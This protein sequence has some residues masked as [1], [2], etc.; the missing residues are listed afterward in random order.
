MALS[1]FGS[2]TTDVK[3]SDDLMT[4]QADEFCRNLPA[5]LAASQAKA[6]NAA[7]DGNISDLLAV[8]ASRNA[9]FT[10]GEGVRMT[11]VTETLR[12]YEPADMSVEPLPLLVYLHGGG[13][14]MGS[15]NS[16][17]R[18]CDAVAATGRAK[19]LA[20]DYRLAP[21]HRY[22]AGLSDCVAAVRY[23]VEHA[24]ELG[25]DPAAISVGGD[26][27]GGNL[28]IATALSAE[29]DGLISS[30]VLFYPVTKAF[31]DG[32]DSWRLY[33]DG[34]GLDSD[35]MDAFNRA[36]I[37]IVPATDRGVNVGLLPDTALSDMPRTLLSRIRA[38]VHN[39][40]G[41]GRGIQCRSAAYGRIRY[42]PVNSFIFLAADFTR[43]IMLKRGLP[44]P[45]PAAE[46]LVTLGGNHE[47]DHFLPE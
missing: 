41:A 38:S 14:A 2:A 6:V 18:Y 11:A 39:C 16:C 4:D 25:V 26:S 33:G 31:A 27:S 17:A 29:C 9:P 21:E 23:A 43:P 20:V 42:T 10:P 1:L 7:A 15:L 45:F 34:Y 46:S 44:L 36:Y 35:L 13:W 47:I 30:L 32:S 22:P 37:G 19:V 8:R 24:A 3:W 12:L 5:G 40:S 28:A